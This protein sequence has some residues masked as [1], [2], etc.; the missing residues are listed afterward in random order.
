MNSVQ[1]QSN[2]WI[3]P[4]LFVYTP[5]WA[6]LYLWFLRGVDVH[7]LKVYYN[8]VQGVEVPISP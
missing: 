4:L 3:K 5:C 1:L 7:D 6:Y 2:T 8:Q